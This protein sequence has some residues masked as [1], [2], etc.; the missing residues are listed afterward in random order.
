MYKNSDESLTKFKKRLKG[1]IDS[2]I[3]EEQ[4]R[5]RSHQ[6]P[7]ARSNSG[8]KKPLSRAASPSVRVAR[9]KEQSDRKEGDIPLKGPDPLDFEPEFVVDDENTISRN[10][11]PQPPAEV[12]QDE[13]SR[14]STNAKQIAGEESHN[15]EQITEEKDVSANPELPTDIRVKLRKLERLESKYNGTYEY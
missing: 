2:R 4:A 7:P 10:E 9:S 1:A 5:Q 15:Q 6:T 12:T 11:T 3:A 14:I 8:A 13:N